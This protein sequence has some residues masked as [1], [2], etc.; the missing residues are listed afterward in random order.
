MFNFLSTVRRQSFPDQNMRIRVYSILTKPKIEHISLIIDR[1]V[2]NLETF[3][4]I[5]PSWESIWESKI[6]TPW[7]TYPTFPISRELIRISKSSTRILIGRIKKIFLSRKVWNSIRR[8]GN[9]RYLRSRRTR[10]KDTPRMSFPE[11]KSSGR[12]VSKS[13]AFALEY[14]YFYFRS[15]NLLNKVLP[16]TDGRSIRRNTW[17][18]YIPP[19]IVIRII[20][21]AVLPTLVYDPPTSLNGI[22]SYSCN[23]FYI[24]TI[25]LNLHFDIDQEVTNS[26][27]SF[28]NP[29]SIRIL[30]QRKDRRNIRDRLSPTGFPIPYKVHFS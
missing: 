26:P 29:D 1:V 2:R 9:N 23:Y 3:T 6:R 5:S 15:F 4:Y 12:E 18:R 17:G 30:F 20:N 8:H 19:F 21:I 27:F 22:I 25:R 13:R 11:A 7:L 24:A 14:S 16:F 28:W 10:L